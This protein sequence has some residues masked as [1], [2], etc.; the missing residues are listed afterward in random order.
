MKK[1][2]I[3]VLLV[4]I[5]LLFAD[6]IPIGEGS[7][8]NTHLPMEPF[9]GY[10]YSQVIYTADEI[11]GAVDIE[12]VAW[13]FNGYAAYTEESCTVYMGH[14]TLDEFGA[15]PSWIPVTELTA[16]WTGPFIMLAFDNW[17]TVDL[18]TPFAY[19]GTDNLVIA[20]DANTVGYGSS[21]SE[22]Y[23]TT[24]TLNR[25]IWY[26]SD[27][28]NP[29]P[30][31]PP[32]TRSDDLGYSELEAQKIGKDA[33][34]ASGVSPYI[35]NVILNHDGI[36]PSGF[37]DGHVYD[38]TTFEPLEGATVNVGG[39]ITTTD[40]MGYYEVEC[41]VSGLLTVNVSHPD[42][43]PFVGNVTVVFD[44]TVTLDVYLE[45]NTLQG[46][47]PGTAIV[48]DAIPYFDS[49][50][51]SMGYTN[52]IGNA[53][54]D[55]FYSMTLTETM[56]LD[57]NL[58][59]SSFDTYL[60]IYDTAMTQVAYND[61]GCP[62]YSPASTINYGDG[63]LL[64][65]GSYYICV[66]GYSSYAGYYELVITP[67][68]I[69]NI[70][71]Y[72]YDLGGTP[73]EGATVAAGGLTATTD[74]TGYFMIEGLQTGFYDVVASADGYFPGTVTNV[75]VL[76]EQTTTIEFN[77]E[78]N[79]TQGDTPA[80]AI[81]IDGY[82]YFDTGDTS[83][84]Y[85]NYIGN[86]SADVFYEFTNN[87]QMDME[88]HCCGST[89]DTYLRLYDTAMTQVAYDDDG[90]SGWPTGSTMASWI[91]QDDG[92]YQVTVAPGTY[93]I[94]LEGY[95]SNTGYYELHVDEVLPPEYGGIEGYVT[96][97][98]TMAPING[99]NVN[100][101]G[102]NAT[103]DA[104]GWYQI[105]G[106]E[107]GIYNVY[108]TATS[109]NPWTET[110]VEILAEQNVQVDVALDPLTGVVFEV[111]VDTYPTEATWNVWDI[112]NQSWIWGTDWSYTTSGQTVL[113]SEDLVDGNY[114]VYCW[115]TYG[116][117]GLSGIVSKQGVILAEW[118]T[119]DYSLEGIFPFTVSPI[120]FGGLEGTVTDAFTGEALGGAVIVCGNYSGT[121]DAT[122]YYNL[123]NVLIGTYDVSCNTAGYTG[124]VAPV[125]ILE[126][127]VTTQDFAL[128]VIMNPPT[129]LTANV[130]GYDVALEWTAPYIPP[131]NQII[132]DDGEAE[133][134][135]AWYDPGN[136]R[137]V[138]FTA[139]ESPCYVTG[140]SMHIYDGSWPAGNILTPF[141]AAVWAYDNGLPGELLGSVEV[142]PTTYEWVPFA[143]DTPIEIIGTDFFLGYIQGGTY[144]DCAPIGVDET[145]P[146]VNRSYEH[147]ATGGED[148]LISTYQDFMLRAGLLGDDGREV[149]L[150]YEN[151][152]ADFSKLPEPQGTVSKYAANEPQFSSE[153][154]QIENV[155]S[156]SREERP[157]TGNYNVYR[158]DILIA[159]VAE[160]MYD[161]L[162]VPAGIHEYY[163][164]AIYDEG[165]SPESNHV[166]V[167]LG[168]ADVVVDPT[169][170]SESLDY[171]LTSDHTIELTNNGDGNFYWSG[172]VQV[173]ARFETP[174]M[175]PR[176]TDKVSDD[177]EMGPDVQMFEVP[178][179][180]EMW[181]L[182]AT[183]QTTQVSQAGVEF[184]GTYFY[185]AVWNTSDINKFD[186]DGNFIE[187]FT[188]PGVTGLRD[189]TYD[190]TY[191]YGGAAGT[192]IWQMDFD[193][194]TLVNTIASPSA[195]RAIAYDDEMDAFWVNNWSTDITLVSRDGVNLDSFPCSLTY[196]SLYGLAYDPYTEGGPYLY[197]FSQAGS[198]CVIS[199]YDIAAGAETGVTHDVL[200]DVGI[201]GDIAGG[202]FTSADYVDGLF[203]LGTLNQN[204]Y[205]FAIYELSPA[206]STN[207]LSIDPAS[208]TLAPGA[209][210]DVNAHFN[211]NQLPGLTY[212]A[213]IIFSDDEV[214]AAVDVDFTITGT[215]PTPE[216]TVDPMAFDVIVPAEGTADYA[217]NIGNL[218]DLALD[219]DAE[220][221]Y[222]EGRAVVEVYPQNVNYWT[223]STD[224]TAFTQTS[225]VNAINLENGWMMF[226]VSGIP[227]NAVIN[228]IDCNVYVNATYYPYWSLTPCTLDPL[229]TDATTLQTH[230]VA[231]NPTGVAYSYNN[232]SSTYAVGWHS[233]TLGTTAN[234]DLANALGQDWFAVGASPRDFST[235]YYTLIDGWNEA[236]PPYLVVDYM[237]PMDPWVTF[238]GEMS[239]SGN[240]PVG[241]GNAVHTLNFDA[242]GLEDGTVMLGDII[243]S[244]N[245]LYNEEVIVPITMTV[246]VPYL[247][248]DVTGD[249]VVDAF[250]AANVLQFTVGMNPVGA[251]L[252]WTWQLIAGDVDGNGTPEAYD[253]A[254]ILQYAVGM[255]D[256]FPVEARYNVPV[257]D[258]TMN[259]VNNE[260]VFSTTGDL[261]GFSV[262]TESELIAFGEPVVAYLSASNGNAV[263]LANAEAIEGEFLRIPFELLEESGELTFT[264][265][266]NGIS[267]DHTYNVEDLEDG[268]ITVNAVLGNYPNPF[269]PTTLIKL[270]TKDNTSVSINIYNVKGQLVKSLVN[271]VA[272]MGYHSYEWSGIDNSNRPVSS[273]VYF[274][275]V[276]MGEDTS[277]HK[278]IMLK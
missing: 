128:D 64:D 166:T 124:Q 201:A 79:T 89:F 148:W 43:F 107:T 217:L 208:G 45:L 117:G 141:T 264:L 176:P 152:V 173:Q 236:N 169:M 251:P 74:A 220:I 177:S 66:E 230:I 219:Y 150:S 70:D 31:N 8:T 63:V 87:T 110:G 132:Y 125:T 59:G 81:V 156:N 140:G 85:T 104:T 162:S 271:E 27:T 119:Y 259:S 12:N 278:M 269:N 126:D 90:C 147:Y 170:I 165:E 39:F 234:A 26:Y 122:G 11:G 182:L 204:S 157:F 197:G 62:N 16:V 238:G 273:G 2:L 95:S 275:K 92:S 180:R 71:G 209:S 29:D 257:A 223:G 75:E 113:V 235:T 244:S 221:M 53:S 211:A 97:S 229:T 239:V 255:I 193:A 198:G 36:L 243:I 215:I 242:A 135:T 153:P 194:H 266:A 142:V 253:A 46:D 202:M 137:A 240:I 206:M 161:D 30:A 24:T 67:L 99:A 218:G 86:T 225:L 195:V 41:L 55:V 263:A 247:Y 268:L 138:W 212:Y 93:Y 231:G 200:L 163:V 228:S 232:E 23:G 88:I 214:S 187:T 151:P 98:E 82:P 69:G 133:N 44:E 262:S 57:I 58:C 184:D 246:G 102:L 196:N 91:G 118:G 14:T 171:G 13:H 258:V 174:E 249:D 78:L 213:D 164:T 32:V 261:Y 50:D 207:W 80:T 49:G 233:Y 145:L 237:V 25:S 47:Q 203:V 123:P 68:G 109:Y 159:T 139:S 254:L 192:V 226:D 73:L 112:A 94:C 210:I 129:N 7:L 227:D 250:D 115:D 72:V 35:A 37:V 252:P 267:S 116:D 175:T 56:L 6:P 181:D 5:G 34:R 33:M 186:I 101:F 167:E 15:Y 38:D 111:T 100:I 121:T 22:F 276:Q 61:D 190:G 10:T 120:L 188:I 134:A 178:E 60:R 17:L 172:A 183:F 136:E 241:G 154:V 76:D 131:A 185:S 65:P 199:Q 103:T 21:G 42:Y 265:V 205:T 18:D 108:Y 272:V 277:T 256:V 28:V 146:T 83:F 260:L 191:F 114:E 9:Y 52:F 160:A 54:P 127:V 216:I 3:A 96:D 149:T 144:P 155:F 20:F 224:G 40:A 4:C 245:D 130:N 106:I 84:G 270:Q 105:T 168:M 77:L 189:L 19:N 248:G 48:V 143:F 51:T 158:N 1:L 274:Y 222:F 179:L